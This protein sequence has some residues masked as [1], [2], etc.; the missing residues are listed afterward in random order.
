MPERM[1]RDD[2]RRG[3]NGVAGKETLN[4]V[5]GRNAVREALNSGKSIERLYVLGGS[6]DGRLAALAADCREN[7]AQIVR[8]DRRRL[9]MMS[10]TGAHQGVI[11]VVADIAYAS[12]SDIFTRAE[13]SG[14]PPLIV[15]CDHIT[16][17]QN[18]GAIIRSAE[19]FGAHGVVIPKRR[20]VSVTPAAVKASAGA[21][22]HMPVVRCANLHAA[23]GE[24]KQAGVWIYGA[25]GMG[26][27]L[28]CETELTSAAAIVLGSEGDGL[29]RLVRDDCDFLVR[30]PMLGK[31]GSLNVSAAAAVFLYEA[32]RQR[33]GAL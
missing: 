22:L 29:S 9:D 15:V 33:Q 1:N 32:L 5:E 14:R 2:P 6:D 21:C 13:E 4:T 8:C 30:I 24:L 31:V 18:L 7:G 28:I 27:R 11:A 26:D 23:I 3:R 20:S 17:P 19:V 10:A 12:L 16:D 25:D